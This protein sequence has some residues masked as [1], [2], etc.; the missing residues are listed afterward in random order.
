MKLTTKIYTVVLLLSIIAGILFALKTD[1][2]IAVRTTLQTEIHAIQRSVADLERFISVS[3]E[4]HDIESFKHM[5]RSVALLL[6]F[7]PTEAETEDASAEEVVQ[8]PPITTETA[9]SVQ[10]L[11]TQESQVDLV[12]TE[13]S[14][15]WEIAQ[16]VHRE[17]NAVR[18][19]HGAP[20]V[21]DH[22]AITS[23][24][25]RH[26][27]DMQN[28]A[29]FA[30]INPRGQKPLARFG[31]MEQLT[32]RTGCRALYSENLAMLTT[33]DNY[34]AF[35]AGEWRLDPEQ[36]AEKVVRMW[37]A[38]TQ[39]HRENMLMLTHR[40]SGIGVAVGVDQGPGYTIYVTQNFCS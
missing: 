18:D 30:H 24:T 31:G 28:N 36:I 23:V 7:E 25:L 26:S 21:V 10:N 12:E 3:A 22:V 4:M 39:G 20:L 27:I 14:M 5:M 8:N 37:M 33:G 34:R 9:A 38:S 19:A 40:L 13:K 1:A 29:Y 16:A 6:S 11:T 2:D 35:I 17:V 32:N 15:A